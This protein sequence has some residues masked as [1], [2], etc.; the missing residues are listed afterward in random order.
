LPWDSLKKDRL[1]DLRHTELGCRIRPIDGFS[2]LAIC[3]PRCCWMTGLL[4]S[5]FLR[6]SP[7]RD[8]KVMNPIP[9]ATDALLL[10]VG[11]IR[12]LRVYFNKKMIEFATNNQI[13]L[14]FS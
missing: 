1:E 8:Q 7:C 3:L 6:R 4:Q 11:T 9:V 10:V 13:D 14:V 5:D 12:R 2:V